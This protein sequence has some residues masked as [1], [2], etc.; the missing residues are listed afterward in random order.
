MAALEIYDRQES[1]RFQARADTGVDLVKI[2]QILRRHVGLAICLSIGIMAT[3]SAA[4]L[5]LPNS[6]EAEALIILNA[7]PS[8][9]TDL[10]SPSEELLTRN[11]ADQSIIKTEI[12]ILSSFHLLKEAAERLDLIHNPLFSD[13]PGSR[14][15]EIWRT[16]QNWM[17]SV[18]NESH[19][20]EADMQLKQGNIRE[21]HA[22][23][24]KIVA[25]LR[26][27]VSVENDGGSYALHLRVVSRDAELSANIANTL[28]GV[29]LE[30][31]ITQQGEVVQSTSTWLAKRLHEMRAAVLDA[32]EAVER[33]RVDHQ[34]GKA[35]DPSLLDTK[36]KEL[37]S[38]LINANV[39]LGRAE[40]D[41]AAAERAISAG[42]DIRMAASVLASS[43][44]Q[45]LRSQEAGILL[46]R[47][48]LLGQFG[49][50]HPKI[51]DVDARLQ[52]VRDK[53]HLE[54][55]RIVAG[56]RSEANAIRGEIS[57][58]RQQLSDLG[59]ARSKQGE[60]EVRLADLER[61]A[62]ASREIY[63][64]F[65]EQ[66]NAAVARQSGQ[67][68]DARLISQA[69]P[70]LE[71]SA[72][73]RK[74][75]LAGA[76][77]GSTVCGMLLALVYGL[78]RGGFIGPDALEQ[79]TGLQTFEMVPE[80]GKAA[81]AGLFADDRL[82]EV[83]NPVRSLAFTLDNSVGP[84]TGGRVLLIT[85]SAAGEGKSFLSV[86]LAR[87]LAFTGRRTLIIDLDAWRPSL[88]R[89]ARN[90]SLVPGTSVHGLPVMMDRFSGLDIAAL[91][92]ALS[93][94]AAL[95]LV[96]QVVTSLPA[97]R[98]T[99]EFVIID[100]PPVLVVPDV[101]PIA[102]RADGTLLIVQFEGP[103]VATVR[104]AIRKLVGAG[105]N[106]LGSVLTRV[107]IKNYR[108]YGYSAPAYL[109]MK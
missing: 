24:D 21:Q 64:K 45:A 57:N 79:E 101:L 11:Q 104:A 59:E 78:R 106:I 54:A 100:A 7:R 58:L 66:F 17:S 102:A 69:R 33:Y 103:N 107:K 70:P 90:L 5:M 37:N 65:L 3:C 1:N 81:L 36:V 35:T 12:E 80:L 26:D 73:K 95:E 50:R 108:R 75:L 13:V 32:D 89:Y 88:N 22:D 28:A 18:R 97:L 14:V 109:R 56:M 2:S 46:E 52:A 42:G 27:I 61:E 31:Q 76:G 98:R 77:I 47:S 74:L 63:Q 38:A 48:T 23:I 86:L 4:I 94:P 67:M 72:P 84:G 19:K 34:L 25:K 29:Y 93:P 53:M 55:E 40:S 43:T 85:S 68:P 20:G 82:P 92:D 30:D 39:R 87:A 105:A 83:A 15:P 96:K 16:W 44:V 49:P 8:K 41:L 99:Y 62:Q 91:Q 60:N 71:P 10:R 9:L 6:Y 51:A